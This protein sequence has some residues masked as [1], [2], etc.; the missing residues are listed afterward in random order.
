MVRYW[1]YAAGPDQCQ[2]YSVDD[3]NLADLAAQRQLFDDYKA[4]GKANPTLFRQLDNEPPRPPFKAIPMR[5]Y[6]GLPF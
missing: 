4:Q 1:R 5:D 6:T 2:F 3:E